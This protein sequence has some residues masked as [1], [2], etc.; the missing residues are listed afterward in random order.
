MMSMTD[1]QQLDITRKLL[2]LTKS[3][4]P[5]L[6]AVKLIGIKSIE[7]GLTTGRS[8]SA[9]MY[10]CGFY[11]FCVG[12]IRSGE[13]TGDLL[14]SLESINLH[15]DKKIKLKK[16]LK[17]S[18]T[19][20]C[21]VGITA[22]LVLFVIFQWVVPTFE[23]MFSNFNAAL[24]WPTQLLIQYSQWFQAYF[25]YTSL[26][27]CCLIVLIVFYWK[28]SANFQK[29]FDRLMMLLPFWGKIRIAAAINQ[30]GKSI[31]TFHQHGIPILDAIKETALNSNDWVIYQFCI[32][33]KNYLSQGWSLSESISMTSHGTMLMKPE[34]LQLI[35]VGE[36]SG[37]LSYV[38]DV[39]ANQEEEALD[40]L[41]DQLSQSM[42]P[43][44][45]IFMGLIVGTLII[46]LY[47]P[48]FE[49]GQ[50]L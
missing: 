18:L 46:A 38:L 3:G 24:P 36:A 7:E 16:K 17:K 34:H 27:V 37:D 2:T 19:Y 44:L 43:V 42:E 21:I 4:L 48:I 39:I 30:W 26:L 5:L 20:P 32:E 12:L 1:Q 50:I 10:Q 11:P 8:L 9:I 41:I 49:M 15:L 45:M 25:L 40:Q 14:A 6:D 31:A 29:K 33:L 22:C 28:Y 23:V 47:L 35:R 13:A